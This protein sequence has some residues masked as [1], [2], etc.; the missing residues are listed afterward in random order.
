MAI[1]LTQPAA[2]RVS[3]YLARG[4]KGIDLRLAVKQTKR[5]SDGI[6][7]IQARGQSPSQVVA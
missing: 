6:V 4:G 3:Q 1:T 2:D 7:Q 5:L